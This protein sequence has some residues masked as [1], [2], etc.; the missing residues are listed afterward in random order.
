MR[1][2]NGTLQYLEIKLGHRTPLGSHLDSPFEELNGNKDQGAS[3]EW[4]L[5]GG[6]STMGLKR[7]VF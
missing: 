2:G 3:L 7:V 1:W 6:S 4:D 5:V